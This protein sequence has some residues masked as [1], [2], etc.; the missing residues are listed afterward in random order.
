MAERP[1]EMSK[2]VRLI[3][4]YGLRMTCSIAHFDLLELLAPPTRPVT[5]TQRRGCNL[6]QENRDDSIRTLDKIQEVWK[7][8]LV[9]EAMKE[10]GPQNSWTLQDLRYEMRPLIF[11]DI[12]FG[13]AVFEISGLA[14]APKNKHGS[15]GQAT[16]PGLDSECCIGLMFLMDAQCVSSLR[17][18]PV[19]F[20]CLS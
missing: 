7:R 4:Q 13:T 18:S 15:N 9:K 1:S 3:W 5:P 14:F 20:F 8:C 17:T 19:L 11:R 10:A 12:P 6:T 2:H 16:K